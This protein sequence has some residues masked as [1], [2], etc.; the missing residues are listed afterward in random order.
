[1]Q[2]WAKERKGRSKV[3][4]DILLIR[5]LLNI[6]FH[7]TRI[8]NKFYKIP[9]RAIQPALVLKWE[10][11]QTIRWEVSLMAIKSVLIRILL[12]NYNLIIFSENLHFGEGG[13]R[14]TS[15]PPVEILQWMPKQC[16][17]AQVPANG[18]YAVD[19]KSILQGDGK[20][21]TMRGLWGRRTWQSDGLLLNWRRL[22]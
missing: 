14:L 18:W 6:S 9:G 13:N 17:E 4:G 22:I 2:R 15:I 5:L 12:S 1:M 3:G 8:N 19:N 20:A 11:F 7:S 21:K 16:K 10:L